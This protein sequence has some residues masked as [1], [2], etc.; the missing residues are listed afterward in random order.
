MAMT[1]VIRADAVEGSPVPPSVETGGLPVPVSPGISLQV[2]PRTR[3]LSRRL[4]VLLLPLIGIA[5]A[6][7]WW[8]MQPG[9]AVPAGI[10]WSNGRLEADEIDIATKFPG[11][12]AEIMVDEGD[13]VH[14]G[15]VVARMDTRDV[16]AQ[17][18]QANAGVQQAEYNVTAARAAL[19]QQ[20]TLL[21]LAAQDLQRALFLLPKGFETRQVVDQRQQ[22]VSGATAGLQAAQAKQNMATAERDAALHNAE[23]IGINIADNTLVTPKDGRIQYRLANVGQVLGAGGKVFTTLDTGYVY[24][25]IFLSTVQAGRVAA[26]TEARILLDAWPARPLPARVMFVDAQNQFTPKAVETKSERDKLMFRVRVR[27]D[28]GLLHANAEKVRSGL[29]GLAYV[30]ID[31]AA[32]WPLNLQL[33][34]GS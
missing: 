5:A 34:A 29:P 14:A 22:A 24:M 30:K 17:L 25:D 11:R 2:R 27:I 16:E 32:Q 6:A 21:I 19:D 23:L 15:Q 18:A 31:Q 33:P 10:A 1:E 28:P 26:G 20:R 13:M 9:A 12:V 8:W 4:A 3:K 7:G